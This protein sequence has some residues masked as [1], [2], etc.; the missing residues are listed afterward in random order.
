MNGDYLLDTNIVIG[1]FAQEQTILDHIADATQVFLS[2]IALGEL[3]YGALKS[4]KPVQNMKRIDEFATGITIL[5][6]DARTAAEYGKI[7]LSLKQVGRPI[8]ENDIWI[9]AI[10]RQYHLILATRDTH[11]KDITGFHSE[12]W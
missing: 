3:Y 1:L 6:C 10:A 5:D 12:N 9:A 8:P 7:K 11:F 2:C 4:G